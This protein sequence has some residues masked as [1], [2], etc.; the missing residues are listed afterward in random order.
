MGTAGHTHTHIVT[1]Y[2]SAYISQ[3]KCPPQTQ[4]FLIAIRFSPNTFTAS[5]SQRPHAELT[6]IH[7]ITYRCSDHFPQLIKRM[8]FHVA[9]GP[10]V[11][12]IPFSYIYF[13]IFWQYFHSENRE[14][15]VFGH[16]IVAIPV[17][18]AA[19]QFPFVKS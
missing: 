15:L 13:H 16:D 10:L 7:L 17:E 11:V 14:I 9:A 4:I 3:V 12:S 18:T 1:A 5:F 2:C 6:H 19:R 8:H